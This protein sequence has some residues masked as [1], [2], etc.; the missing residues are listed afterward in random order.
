MKA[1]YFI[2]LLVAP[3]FAWAGACCIGGGPRS[4]VQLRDLQ[5]YD[6]GIATSIRD[7]YGRYNQYGEVVS[8]EKLQTYTMALGASARLFPRLEGFA[9]VPLVGKSHSVGLEE[10]SAVNLGDVLVGS[11]LTLYDPLF[12]EDWF[13][14][15]KMTVSVKA[16][17]GTTDVV[18][19]GN[20]LW[21]PSLGVQMQ[22][23]FTTI[24]AGIAASYTARL[25]RSVANP[26]KA[27]QLSVKEGDRI[28][29]TETVTLPIDTS[30]SVSGGSSQVWDL[31]TSID[32]KGVSDSQGRYATALLSGT[33]FMTRFWK[34]TAAFEGVLPV[35]KLGANEDAYRSFTVTSTYAIY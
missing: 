31:G 19:S 35:T 3:N 29:V 18:G 4:F 8:A 10:R 24:I 33:Y 2:L 17:S 27:E 9:I 26:S 6:L 30:F 13:P 12:L 23:D 22:K 20:G 7:N 32:G 11:K 21:E 28:E 34:M 15:T 5:S 1:L 14:E 16:P 25:P